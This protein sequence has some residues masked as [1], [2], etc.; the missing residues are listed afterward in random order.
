MPMAARPVGDVAGAV[1]SEAVEE[2]PLVRQVAVRPLRAATHT[3]E[4]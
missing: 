4:E 1:V 2:V 3:S